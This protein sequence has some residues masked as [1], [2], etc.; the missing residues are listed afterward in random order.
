MSIKAPSDATLRQKL[1]QLSRMT[2]TLPGLDA[3]LMVAQYTS[4]LVVALLLKIAKLRTEVRVNPAAVGG[5][6]VSSLVEIAA[7]WAR[8]GGSIGDARVI[9]RAAGR[10]SLSSLCKWHTHG[11]ARPSSYDSVAACTPPTSSASAQVSP[12]FQHLGQL[13]Q[14][15]NASDATSA[16]SVV[17]LPSRA[18]CLAGKQGSREDQPSSYRQSRA[19]ECPVL[20]VSLT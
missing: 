4:P 16:L 5:S 8:V 11:S 13:V 10:S 19:L 14:P 15:K 7:G 2:G 18:H 6:K 12:D 20:G 3:T 1:G 9:M 17:L